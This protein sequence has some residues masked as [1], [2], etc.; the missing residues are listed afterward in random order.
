MKTAIITGGSVNQDFV[1]KQLEIGNYDKLVAVDHGGE[2]FLQSK[3]V[4]D[5][6]VGDFDS[7][8]K[9]SFFNIRNNGKTKILRF[10]P[11]KD[12]TDT[13]LA[14]KYAIENGATS[15]DIYGATG[16]RL[17]HVLGNIQLLCLGLKHKVPCHIIDETN[18]IRVIDESLEIEKEKQYG[19][20]VSILPLTTKVEGV[21]LT[22][23]KYP[24]NHFLL[25]GGRALG[26]S[27]EIVDDVARIQVEDGILVVIE[28]KDKA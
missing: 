13:E 25:E 21:T 26:V 28:S 18:R 2:F 27:N 6:M 19:F 4:P 12:D 1:E 16:T 23:M 24:L 5:F 8:E 22:G 3:Y 14:I 15:I 9:D 11:E 20:Y 17:D 10:P 7:I